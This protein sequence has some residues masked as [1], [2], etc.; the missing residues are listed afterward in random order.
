[1]WHFDCEFTE[2]AMEEERNGCGIRVSWILCSSCSLLSGL[3][4]T[5][6][7]PD[8]HHLTVC[9]LLTTKILANAGLTALVRND[10]HRYLSGDKYGL[11][12]LQYSLTLS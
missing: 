12:Q 3:C 9:N 7:D 11:I 10:L 2:N 4:Y 6:A 8:G 5:D 1:M